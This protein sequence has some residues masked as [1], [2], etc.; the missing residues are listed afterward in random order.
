MPTH[1]KEKQ[2]Q[3]ALVALELGSAH[4]SDKQ[5]FFFFPWS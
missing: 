1:S 5:T 4:S 3:T 2:R